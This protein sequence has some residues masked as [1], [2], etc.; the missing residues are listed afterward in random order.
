MSEI[1]LALLFQILTSV[2][3][4]YCMGFVIGVLPTPCCPK[5]GGGSESIKVLCER[6]RWRCRECGYKYRNPRK[7]R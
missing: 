2:E 6:S 5:C 1:I 4:Y 3:F 7:R